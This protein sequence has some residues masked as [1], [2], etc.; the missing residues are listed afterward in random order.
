MRS[1][2]VRLSQMLSSP[3]VPIGFYIRLCFSNLLISIICKGKDNY[4][5]VRNKPILLNTLKPNTPINT[6]L[7]H[8][9]F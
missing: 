5:P 2:S 6:I 4:F 9:L 7:K 1:R 3:F 8:S